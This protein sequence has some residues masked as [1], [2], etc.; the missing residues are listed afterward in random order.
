MLPIA[1]DA[2]DDF[3]KNSDMEHLRQRKN[4]ATSSATPTLNDCSDQQLFEECLKRANTAPPPLASLHSDLP[5]SPTSY[6]EIFQL[7]RQFILEN[8]TNISSGNTAASFLNQP[9]PLPQVRHQPQSHDP[10]MATKE[11][12]SLSGACKFVPSTFKARPWSVDAI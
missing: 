11:K 9:E 3:S 1:D 4:V 7:F 12:E 8:N 2:A 10:N 6:L 5:A